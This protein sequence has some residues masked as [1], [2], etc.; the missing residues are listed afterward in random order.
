M[1]RHDD[2]TIGSPRTKRLV[3]T[4]GSFGFWR[5]IVADRVSD[6]YRELAWWLE[7][8]LTVSIGRGDGCV[9]PTLPT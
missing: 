3:S 7:P 4:H 1:N 9:Y 2:A 5:A 8:F 6:W